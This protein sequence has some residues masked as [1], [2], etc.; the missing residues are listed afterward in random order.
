MSI[1]RKRPK[2][3]LVY[4]KTQGQPAI[5]YELYVAMASGN[6]CY[7]TGNKEVIENGVNR[8][9]VNRYVYV[10]KTR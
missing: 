4:G 8:K 1:I 7:D 6:N 10:V 3:I 5:Q 9:I 2:R